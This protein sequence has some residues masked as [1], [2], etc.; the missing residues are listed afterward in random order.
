MEQLAS[1]R[2][3]QKVRLILT[4]HTCT[5]SYIRKKATL[6]LYYIVD[7]GKKNRN[8]TSERDTRA[9]VII[10]SLTFEHTYIH[11][12]TNQRKRHVPVKEDL[13]GDCVKKR[14]RYIYTTKIRVRMQ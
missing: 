5:K 11:T 1:T 9:T 14:A 6:Q 3:E 2:I 10:A 8:N 7:K 13:V 4:S 12:H